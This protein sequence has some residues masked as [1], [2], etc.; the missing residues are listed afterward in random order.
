[1]R[2]R[3]HGVLARFRYNDLKEAAGGCGGY[4]L[5]AGAGL[6]AMGIESV[7]V[8]SLLILLGLEKSEKSKNRS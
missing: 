7:L 8:R 5:K 3:E 4:G 6:T 1:M 2:L